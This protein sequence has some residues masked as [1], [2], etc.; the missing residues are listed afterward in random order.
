MS[1]GR[2]LET[3]WRISSMLKDHVL[4]DAGERCVQPSSSRGEKG[5]A[6]ARPQGVDEEDLDADACLNKSSSLP[7]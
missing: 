1:A 4:K 3:T 6:A 2:Q 7:S 5:A